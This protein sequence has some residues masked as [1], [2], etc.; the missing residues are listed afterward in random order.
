[1]TKIQGP[2]GLQQTQ[3]L[4]Q[5]RAAKPDKKED[6]GITFGSVLSGVADAALSTTA[7]VAP[8]VP[9]GGLI[10][11]AANGLYQIKNG[12]QS[13]GG[14]MGG[15]NGEQM[16]KMWAMQRENQMFNMQYM[17][18]QETIQSDNR[19]FSTLSNLLKV[20]HDTAKSAINNMHA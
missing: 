2:Q 9:G 1:M 18:L 13:P 14:G 20:R 4:E 11:A 6:K 16:D 17:Q 7:A 3:S 5:Q 10:G 15:A 12:G 8:L 19:N